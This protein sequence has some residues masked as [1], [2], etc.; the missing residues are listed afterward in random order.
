M[1]V[2]GFDKWGTALGLNPAELATPAPN[3]FNT[4]DA[5]VTEASFKADEWRD[6]AK[7]N[8]N[9]LGMLAFPT[10]FQYFFPPILLA[11]WQL[12][13]Q[14]ALKVRDFSQIVLAI[15]RGHGKTTLVKLFV[16][17]CILFT[18]KS[19][20]L[21]IGATESKAE[22]IVADVMDMLK[23]QNIIKLFGDYRVGLEKDTQSLK[24]FAFRSRSIT[25]AG[26][27][28]GTSLRGLN[29]KNARP[30]LML[31]D[32]IQ[33][34]DDAQSKALSEAL[35]R[36]LIGTAM[37]AKSPFGCTF[38]F[39]GNVFATPWSLIKKLQK[40]PRWVKFMTGAILADGTALWPELYPIS[41]LMDEFE[42][43]LSL[44]HP[45]IFFAEVLNNPEAGLKSK[46]DISAVP[47][48]PWLE[49]DIPQGKFLIIDPATG[50]SSKG[51]YTV[52]TRCEVYDLVPAAVEIREEILSPGD[53]IRAALVWC[54]QHNICLIG[55]EATAYQATLLYWF[56]FFCK[57]LMIGDKIQL[58]ELT[59]T[60]YSKNARITTMLSCLQKGEII[61]HPSVR[62]QVLTQ[63]AHWNPM[64]RDNIDGIL[65]TFTYIP[66]IVATYAHLMDNEVFFDGF[67]ATET[68]VHNVAEN[69]PY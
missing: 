62:A 11:V 45:E 29:L 7:V 68:R 34:E 50:K 3:D 30:D 24:K 63:A 44:G 66:T 16:L 26:I 64:K 53:C 49:Q 36:W 19:F 17:W 9:V 65:D 57:Q 28:A 2:A 21:I 6:N 13:T 23:E 37:K 8:V 15:P 48:W 22:N 31:F 69:C 20:I 12:I 43:D 56:D 51:D 14:A 25:I 59:N 18:K 60:Q 61:L 33:D 10:V 58:V 1:P 46:L 67:S 38:I 41:Q 32:D 55:V 40:S 47:E 4:P 27:G 5:E 39:I 42:N 35:E 52:I 54:I